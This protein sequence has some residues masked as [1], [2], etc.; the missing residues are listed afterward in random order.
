MLG[1]PAVD[2]PPG[3]PGNRDGTTW[4][5]MSTA[6]QVHAA[7]LSGIDVKAPTIRSLPAVPLIM[8]ILERKPKIYKFQV[9]DDLCI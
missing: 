2:T 7:L 4:Q 1:Q 6:Q 8:Q 9:G 3:A 5:W